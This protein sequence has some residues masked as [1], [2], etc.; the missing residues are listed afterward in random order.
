MKTPYDFH[1]H[2]DGVAD[3]SLALQK[4]LDFGRNRSLAL[5]DGVFN[6]TRSL[7]QRNQSTIYGQG[8]VIVAAPGDQFPANAHLLTN[9]H[10]SNGERLDG[11]LRLINVRL[12]GDPNRN[13]FGS[14][15]AFVGVNSPRVPGCEF[16]HWRGIVFQLANARDAD[17]NGLE[18]YDGGRRDAV[19][20]PGKC[21]YDGGCTLWTQDVEDVDA[22]GLSIRDTD[23]SG[24]QMSGKRWVLEDFR[25]VRVRECG[26][27][28]GPEDSRIRHGIIAGVRLKDCS[29][30]GFEL[31]G[32]NYSIDDVAVTDCDGTNIYLSNV[33]GVDVRNCNLSLP[34]QQFAAD[35]PAQPGGYG[36]ITFRNA[37]ELG[38][39][40][41]QISIRDNT[42]SDASGKSTYGIAVHDF[43]GGGAFDDL[44]ITDNNLGD[45]AQWKGQPIYLAPG[46]RGQR[47]VI[48]G[49]KV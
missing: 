49:E 15:V 40:G 47:C 23:W 16:G 9:E 7:V 29:S 20:D 46:A 4:W 28:G 8:G 14:L 32:R 12:Q 22:R 48:Q 39:P 19:P 31:G 35:G 13:T 3:D 2:G 41:K 27:F 43:A 21:A 5:T 38:P 37:A 11:D 36:A 25:I 6:C 30:H 24:I 34:N 33:V 18:L 17:L 42:I 1:A 45:P 26:I 10:I 44:T